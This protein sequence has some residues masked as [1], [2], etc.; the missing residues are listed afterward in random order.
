MQL[1]TI[2]FIAFILVSFAFYYGVGRIARRG[3][4]IVLLVASLVFYWFCGWQNLLFIG[5]TALSTWLAGRAFGSLEQRSK[6]E[7]KA[8]EDRAQKKEIKKCYTTRKRLVLAAV[9]LVNFG[10]LSYIKYADVLVHAIA[11]HNGWSAGIL[12]PLGISF[13]TFQSASYVIDTYNAKYE[14]E[15]SFW[16]YLLFV[17]FFPQL[18]QG[19]INRFDSLASQLYETRSFDFKESRKALLQIGYGL[20]KK[21]VLANILIKAVNPILDHVDP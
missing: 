19:P 8:C 7:R 3:Q 14:P 13:Y 21:F 1:Y 2:A 16:R 20:L 4:W 6:K 12:L 10:V 11:P 15:G 9:L 18:I 17:S 5:L